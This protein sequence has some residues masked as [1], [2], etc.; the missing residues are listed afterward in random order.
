MNRKK[1]NIHSRPEEKEIQDSVNFVTWLNIQ[2]IMRI[3][4]NSNSKVF[5]I[6]FATRRTEKDQSQFWAVDL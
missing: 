6:R 1:I 4:I 2:N 5:A 3:M